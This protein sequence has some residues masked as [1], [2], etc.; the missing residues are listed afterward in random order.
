MPRGRQREL[1]KWNELEPDEVLEQYPFEFLVCRTGHNWPRR[2]KGV[3]WVKI[4]KTLVER[5]ATCMS[6]GSTQV[7]VCDA[8]TL[9]RAQPQA[10]I[11][12]TK[13]YLT[14]GTGLTQAD[15][16]GALYQRDY[17]DAIEGGRYLEAEWEEAS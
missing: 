1:P 3:R 16:E 2:G 11:R 15:F 7:K 17:Q 13:G 10:K 12:H 4:S 5:R 8:T 14:G 6:C 9:R